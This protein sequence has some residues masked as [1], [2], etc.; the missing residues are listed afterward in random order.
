MKTEISCLKLSEKTENIAHFVKFWI[1]NIKICLK[2]TEK[3]QNVA[4]FR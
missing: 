1:K 2:L 4:H 3:T